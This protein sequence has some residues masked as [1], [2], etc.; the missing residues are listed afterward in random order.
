MKQFKKTNDFL[1]A[2][3]FILII[4]GLSFFLIPLI[5]YRAVGFFYLVTI[6]VMATFLRSSALIYSA[7]IASFI[8]NFFFITPQFTFAIHEKEDF[9]MVISFFIAAVIGS[10]LALRIKRQE[11][12]LNNLK[13]KEHSKKLSD[14]LINSVSHEMRTPLT[15]LMGSATALKE[16][17]IFNNT[18]SRETLTNE[19]IISAKRL[20]RVIENL[21]DVGRMDRGDYK[22]KSEW[23]SWEDFFSELD[24]YMGDELKTCK[25]SHTGQVTEYVQGDFTLLL[26]AYSNLISNSLKHS[27]QKNLEIEINIQRVDTFFEIRYMDNGKGVASNLREKIFDKFFSVDNKPSGLGLGLALV[28]NIIELHSGSIVY[29][30]GY[31]GA[32]FLIKLPL[33]RSFDLDSK[34]NP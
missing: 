33:T 1:V 7:F 28:R 18:T 25:L 17:A 8:W 4:T 27:G 12:L 34:V 13:L 20:N 16:K 14:T 15:V 5:G 30:E 22:L 32:A 21:L 29:L 26:H 19:I 2:T 24:A 11:V 23:F 3:T 6:L 31:K 10:I 9:M